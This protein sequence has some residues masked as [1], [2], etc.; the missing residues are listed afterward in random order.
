MAAMAALDGAPARAETLAALSGVSGLEATLEKLTRR[1]IVE[2]RV[3]GYRLAGPLQ[4]IVQKDWDLTEWRD[5]ALTYL[6]AWAEEQWRDHR[7]VEESSAALLSVFNWALRNGRRD[8][9]KR[10]G[11]ALDGALIL[12]GRWEAWGQVL[13][14]VGEA[15]AAVGDGAT[16]AWVLHQQGSRAL[17]MGDDEAARRYL[18]KRWNAAPRW[19]ITPRPRPRA[20]IWI[21]CFR[22]SLYTG[23]HR[24]IRV[25][26]R[27]RTKESRLDSR[28]A[29]IPRSGF[30][31]RVGRVVLLARSEAAIHAR[32]IVVSESAAQSNERAAD[33]DADQSGRA[34]TGD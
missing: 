11:K 1:K 2:T 6:T 3:D 14:Q 29:Q 28:L 15:A 33:S 5:R 4:A 19:A 9:A 34:R 8:E 31:G 25:N 22:P 21:G 30:A 27:L 18:P 23:I 20:T 16:S 12:S 10:L 32:A 24:G 13:Q 7:R 26:E 17:C